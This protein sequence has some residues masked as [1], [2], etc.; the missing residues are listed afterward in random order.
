[1]CINVLGDIT[2]ISK[3]AGSAFDVCQK[4]EAVLRD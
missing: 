2:T 4:F 1:M 3:L